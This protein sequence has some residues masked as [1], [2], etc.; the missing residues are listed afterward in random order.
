MR[1]TPGWHSQLLALATSRPGTCAPS[2]RAGGQRR[3][4]GRPATPARGSR[5]VAARPAAARRRRG[6]SGRRAAAAR[7][8][9]RPAPP[10][11]RWRTVST[12]GARR[13]RHRPSTGVGGAEVDA[14]ERRRRRWLVEWLVRSARAAH[15]ELEL[16]ALAPSRAT[17]ASSSVPTSVTRGLQAHRHQSPGCAAC[18]PAAWPRSRASSSSSSA[19]SARA[20][21]RR[22]PRGAPTRRRSGSA[23]ARRRRGR[24]PA[25]GSRPGA[26]LHAERRD[27]QRLHRR[28]DAGHGGHRRSPRRRSRR[29]R[30][31]RGCAGR[32]PRRT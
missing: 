29:A 13:A 15:V 9:P 4:R 1:S 17:A 31:R 26:L 3:P 21:C 18:R 32:A 8:R 27:A 22:G 23:P 11:A 7:R 24:T 6:G 5:A 30:C 12:G 10:A 2:L 25:P 14:D 19:P 16:P 20:R 28:L